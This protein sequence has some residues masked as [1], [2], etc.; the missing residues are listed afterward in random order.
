MRAKCLQQSAGDHLWSRTE[1]IHCLSIV[2]VFG[3]CF[4]AAA[5]TY[6]WTV[7]IRIFHSNIYRFFSLQLIDYAFSRI[8]R[9][10][11]WK[12]K[13]VYCI[14]VDAFRINARLNE[15]HWSV[16]Q[17]AVR[18]LTCFFFI[19]NIKLVLDWPCSSIGHFKM[20]AHNGILEMLSNEHVEPLRELLS[21]FNIKTQMKYNLYD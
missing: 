19:S 8:L 17:L 4:A 16:S 11:V 7:E 18:H 13:L 14:W 3:C 1:S 2:C 5:T 9:L 12:K 6:S 10:W 15:T 20:H 21:N